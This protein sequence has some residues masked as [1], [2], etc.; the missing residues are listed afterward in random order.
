MDKKILTDQEQGLKE[1]IK[2]LRAQE[3]KHIK[4]NTLTEQIEKARVK[5]DGLKEKQSKAKKDKAGLEKKKE[6]SLSGA[7]KALAG[8][9]TG[10]LPEGIA[11]FSI[12][13]GDVSVGWKRNDTLTPYLGLSGGEKAIFDLAMSKALL[14]DSKEKILIGEIAEIDD[15]NAPK[16][17]KT[18]TKQHPDAQI[19][20]NTCHAIKEVPKE[21]N[22][23]QLT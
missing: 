9:I 8:K 22:V 19:I 16:L 23:V 14:G 12:N 2:S 20:L 10:L 3:R 18:I 21:W 7:A 5:A 1:S 4:Y 13:D 6:A 15:V 11:I 17:L